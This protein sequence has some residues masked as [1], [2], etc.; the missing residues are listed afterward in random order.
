ME[1]CWHE[2]TMQIWVHGGNRSVFRRGRRSW[3]CVIWRHSFSHFY[4]KHHTL[5]IYLIETS[6]W[7]CSCIFY[8]WWVLSD[9]AIRETWEPRSM[10]SLRQAKAGNDMKNIICLWFSHFNLAE[11][12]RCY[13]YTLSLYFNTK[14][15]HYGRCWHIA[16]ERCEMTFIST[17]VIAN[18][19]SYHD[20]KSA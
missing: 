17:H 16:V 15:S 18:Q 19:N 11:T 5:Q 4:I 9:C 14:D 6:N 7:R 13:N 3:N 1:A 8:C 10:A 2:S 20:D 12:H